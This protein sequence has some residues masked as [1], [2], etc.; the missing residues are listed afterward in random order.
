MMDQGSLPM[1]GE[2][3]QQ[4]FCCFKFQRFWV[5]I[6]APDPVVNQLEWVQAVAIQQKSGRSPV[7]NGPPMA[8]SARVV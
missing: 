1:G 3:R 8:D 4:R 7:A 2:Y 5:L 6:S